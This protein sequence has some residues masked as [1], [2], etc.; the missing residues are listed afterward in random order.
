MACETCGDTG[1]VLYQRKAKDVDPGMY[2]DKDY[3]ITFA[4]HCRY[5]FPKTKQ[6]SWTNDIENADRRAHEQTA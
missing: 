2:K 4:R 3:T 5:C 6:D 1:W